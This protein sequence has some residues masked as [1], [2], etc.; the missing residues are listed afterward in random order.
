MIRTDIRLGLPSKGILRDGALEFLASCGLK[1]FRPNPRQYAATIPNLPGV[2]VLFQRPGDIVVGVRQGSLDFGITG[3]DILAEKAFG[4]GSTLT[5]H[6]ALGFGPCTL[7]LAV[8][9]TLA[10]RRM[11]DLVKWAHELNKHGRSLRVAT[12]FPNLTRDMLDRN[13]VKPYRLISPEGTLEIAPAIGFA[14]VIADLVSSGITLRDNHLRILEDGLILKSEACL[15]ANRLALRERG[16]VLDVAR[17]LLEFTE[18]YLRAL[19]SYVVTANVRSRSP[20]AIARRMFDQTTLGGL[21]GPTISRVVA[22]EDL[23]NGNGWYAINIIVRKAEIFQAVSEIRQIGGSGVIVTPC[24]Y[25]FEEEPRRYQAMLAA[26]E[27]KGD[28]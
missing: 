16:E 25:I 17:Q 3:Y 26:L 21:Q 10:P 2:T 14:D 7:N 20:E 4:N 27:D 12:K 24:T 28:V 8:P 1:V 19:G 15:I 22:R 13:G 9:E 11:A 23:S 5:L 6:D 18:A